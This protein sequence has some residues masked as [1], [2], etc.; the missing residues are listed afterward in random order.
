M[1]FFANGVIPRDP[2]V[3]VKMQPAV[4]ETIV[5]ELP[6]EAVSDPCDG[7][8]DLE[9]VLYYNGTVITCNNGAE[10]DGPL[11]IGAEE[12]LLEYRG[13]SRCVM[14]S[15]IFQAPDSASTVHSVVSVGE[16]SSVSAITGNPF[17][18]TWDLRPGALPYPF[19]NYQQAGDP[20]FHAEFGAN[21]FVGG[22][23]TLD[24]A[25]VLMFGYAI[26]LIRP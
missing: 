4:K 10:F 6:E 16:Y 3:R 19:I 23:P 24:T 5:I 22:S 18:V 15:A 26:V 20:G 12:R 21:I 14:L 13:N 25:G 9:A 1:K 8:P 11:G 2:R 17:T 7:L